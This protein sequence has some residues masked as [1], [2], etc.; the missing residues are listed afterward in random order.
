M[1]FEVGGCEVF[2]PNDEEK[3]KECD[4]KKFNP[5]YQP[6]Y[7]RSLQIEVTRCLK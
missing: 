2:N 3:V 7:K 4:K 1:N 6:R 5:Q